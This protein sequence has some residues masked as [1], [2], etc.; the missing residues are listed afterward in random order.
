MQKNSLDSRARFD[1]RLVQPTAH[2]L[3]THVV[4]GTGDNRGG[5]KEEVARLVETLV[6]RS[7]GT[8]T[9]DNYRGKWNTWVKERKAQGKATWLH[10]V[11]DPNEAPTE[12]LKF[13]TSRCFVHR[14]TFSQVVHRMAATFVALHDRRKGKGDR[15]GARTVYRGRNMLDCP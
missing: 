11:T 13:M 7:V 6:L 1:A 3:Y 4:T 5:N 9:Q 15:Q 14:L 10:T 12:R 8:S 2:I